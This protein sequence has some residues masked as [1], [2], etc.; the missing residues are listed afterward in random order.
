MIS[1]NLLNFMHK[2]TNVILK[3]PRHQ[4]LVLQSCHPTAP[5]SQL[6]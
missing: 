2:E 3:V 6:E 5:P 4:I 1:F